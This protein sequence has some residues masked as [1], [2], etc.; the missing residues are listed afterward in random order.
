M[1]RFISSLIAAV[2]LAIASLGSVA[3]MD[4]TYGPECFT[5]DHPHGYICRAVFVI[6]VPGADIEEVLARTVGDVEDLEN[7]ADSNVARGDEPSETAYRSWT[8]LLAEGDD[9]LEAVDILLADPDVE[10]ASWSTYGELTGSAGSEGG[11]DTLPDTAMTA[12]AQ[13]TLIG[14]MLVLVG[15][16][17]VLRRQVV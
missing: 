7:V 13:L 2:A 16:G 10:D 9:A 8:I 12:T 15:G 4:G 6:L 17:L 5:P 3:A 14:V 1:T 11:A